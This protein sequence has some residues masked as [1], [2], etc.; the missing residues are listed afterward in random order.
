M[1]KQ[2]KV[3]AIAKAYEEIA[4]L[5]TIPYVPFFVFLGPIQNIIN[6]P[7]TCFMPD[8]SINKR[9]IDSDR[10]KSMRSTT[11]QLHCI[12]HNGVERVVS[13]NLRGERK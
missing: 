5:S 6:T 4:K 12:D 2:G 8:G 9:K 3:L 11:S 13:L 7:H 1:S 10:R